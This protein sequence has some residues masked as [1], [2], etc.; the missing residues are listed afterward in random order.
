M[1]REEYRSARCL[2]IP[3]L[4]AVEADDDKGKIDEER[5][6]PMFTIPRMNRAGT[7][8]SLHHARSYQTP[9]SLP[10]GESLG[11]SEDP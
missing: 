9:A 6:I 4:I 5:V 8:G 11:L 10:C 1:R 3:V 2:R 7:T